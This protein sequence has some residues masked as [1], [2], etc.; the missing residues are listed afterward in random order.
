MYRR[1]RREKHEEKDCGLDAAAAGSCGVP[2]LED[3]LDLFT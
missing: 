2:E 1:R 3:S